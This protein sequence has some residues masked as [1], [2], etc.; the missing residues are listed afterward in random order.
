MPDKPHATGPAPNSSSWAC[1]AGPARRHGQVRG[2]ALGS[3]LGLWQ[4]PPRLRLLPLATPAEKVF[5]PAD[6]YTP[7]K[8]QRGGA[9]P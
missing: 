7:L 3:D 4:L 2:V 9:P 6:S 8:T 1:G 5:R